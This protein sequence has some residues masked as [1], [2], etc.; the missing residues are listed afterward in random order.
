MTELVE[1][2]Q[3]KILIKDEKYAFRNMKLIKVQFSF[4]F[5][6]TIGNIGE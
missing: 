1:G 6:K 2:E 3:D 5:L 4:K